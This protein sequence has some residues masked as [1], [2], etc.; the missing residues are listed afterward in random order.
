ML[1]TGLWVIGWYGD[2]LIA[3]LLQVSLLIGWSCG[4][5]EGHHSSAKCHKPILWHPLL[6]IFQAKWYL[7]SYMYT[8]GYIIWSRAAVPPAIHIPW[9][10]YSS[11]AMWPPM[12][13]LVGTD[14]LARVCSVFPLTQIT[15]GGL[16]GL[17]S[18]MQLQTRVMHHDDFL[19]AGYVVDDPLPGCFAVSVATCSVVDTIMLSEPTQWHDWTTQSSQLQ[20][21]NCGMSL[22]PLVIHIHCEPL[23]TL[24]TSIEPTSVSTSRDHDSLLFQQHQTSR[25]AL[26]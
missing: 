17:L 6:Q 14:Q 24:A 7:V 25:W 16:T 19:G 5:F 3:W 1:N 10:N 21:Q 15:S 8:Y 22:M 9:P 12:F 23:S 13:W 26:A 4:R 2:G 11:C 18:S 20:M